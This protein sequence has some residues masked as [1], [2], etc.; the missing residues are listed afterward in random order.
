MLQSMDA[1]GRTRLRATR[2][3]AG[4]SLRC[5][6]RGCSAV[7][8]REARRGSPAL[9]VCGPGLGQKPELTDQAHVSLRKTGRFCPHPTLLPICPHSPLLSG[10]HRGEAPGVQVTSICD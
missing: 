3:G 6:S 10:G 8:S 9:R 5:H 7:G 2:T 1:N 4:T